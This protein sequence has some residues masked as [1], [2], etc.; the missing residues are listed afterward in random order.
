M[1]SV[2]DTKGR[3][4]GGLLGMTPYVIKLFELVRQFEIFYHKFIR[5]SLVTPPL[6]CIQFLPGVTSSENTMQ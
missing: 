2:S 3:L 6:N 4:L 5:D 1:D